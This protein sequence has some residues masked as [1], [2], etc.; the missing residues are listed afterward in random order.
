MIITHPYLMDYSDLTIIKIRFRCALNNSPSDSGLIP[1][2]HTYCYTA[3]KMINMKANDLLH[4]LFRLRFAPNL[5][6]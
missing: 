4:H 2:Q 6:I 1:V 5:S 3:A